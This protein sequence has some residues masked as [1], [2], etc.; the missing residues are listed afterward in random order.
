LV[1]VLISLY[2]LMQLFLDVL[3][4]SF[5]LSLVLIALQNFGLSVFQLLL[6]HQHRRV[7]VLILWGSKH[8]CD[9]EFI[10]LF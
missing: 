8:L 6:A 9:N 5:K 1:G 2:F 10:N 3:Q 4:R 7:L